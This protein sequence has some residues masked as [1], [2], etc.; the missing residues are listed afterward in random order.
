[1]SASTDEEFRSTSCGFSP[2]NLCVQ[3][4]MKNSHCTP[5]FL[6]LGRNKCCIG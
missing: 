5:V 4:W 2:G 1:M 3:K 6:H